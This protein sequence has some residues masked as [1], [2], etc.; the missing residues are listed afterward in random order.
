MAAEIHKNDIGTA[1]RITIIDENSVA[2][3]LTISDTLYI[4]FKKPNDD[5]LQKTAT[6]YSAN[7][8][9]IEYITIDGDLNQTGPWKIQGYI[10]QG[11]DEF[12][13]SISSFKVWPNLTDI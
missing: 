6:I 11:A 10:R 13:S 8:G 12:Y 7:E 9:I 4:I 3:P 5:V 2:V 1:F